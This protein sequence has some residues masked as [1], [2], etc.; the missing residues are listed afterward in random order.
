MPLSSF[1]KI[2]K[3]LS[4]IRH[5]TAAHGKFS[6]LAEMFGYVFLKQSCLKSRLDGS[7]LKF[8]VESNPN[9]KYQWWTSD[10]VFSDVN[11][12]PPHSGEQHLKLKISK[13]NQNQKAV[14]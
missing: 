7:A 14:N 4:H 8:Y 2:I 11:V 10:V 6:N 3:H 12:A 1:I 5:F 13:C 9:I